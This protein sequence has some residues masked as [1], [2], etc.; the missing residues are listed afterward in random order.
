MAARD[1]P[2]ELSSFRGGRPAAGPDARCRCAKCRSYVPMID[3]SSGRLSRHFTF[4]SAR[5]A[6]CHLALRGRQIVIR[7]DDGWLNNDRLVGISYVRKGICKRQLTCAYILLDT[8][9]PR[10]FVRGSQA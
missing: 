3:T 1:F 6:I 7:T 2:K 10:P 5:L 4:G 8:C 9:E